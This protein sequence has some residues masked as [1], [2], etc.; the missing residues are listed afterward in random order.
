MHVVMAGDYPAAP[1]KIAHGVE[2]VVAYLTDHLQTY[3]DLKLSVVTLDRRDQV[4]RQVVEYENMTIHYVPPARLPS[5]LSAI[6]SIQRLKEEINQLQPDLVHVQ[7]ANEYAEAA[8]A[9]NYPWVLTLHGIRFKEVELWQGFVDKTYRGWFVKREERRALKHAKH[10]ISIS[11]FI[12]DTFNGQLRGQVYDIENPIAEAYFNLSEP[13]QTHQLL[14]AGQLI[15]RKGVHILL[16]AF[17]KLHRR[18]PQAT[19]RLAG[20]GGSPNEVATYERDLKQ[21]VDDHDLAEHVFFLGRLDETALLKEYADCSALVLS[22]ILETAPMVVMQAMAAGRAVVSTNVGGSRYLVEHGQ[23]GLIVPPND[24]DALAA[25]LEQILSD[26]TQ[27]QTMGRRAQAVAKQR[28]HA[29]V[30]AARTR[31]IYYQVL[32]QIPPKHHLNGSEH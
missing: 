19:L 3:P 20:S 26:E 2:A 24:A 12:Q 7:V 27:L 4:G 18:L 31:A 28:F 1:N 8:A 22:S 16:Q 23:T 25:A 5:Y 15:P 11:P 9:L 10:V 29:Q 14:F 30:V 13:G 32:G 17:A 6:G 21:F